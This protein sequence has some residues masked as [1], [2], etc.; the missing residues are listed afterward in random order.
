MLISE[1]SKFMGQPAELLPTDLHEPRCMP[2]GVSREP[3]LDRSVLHQVRVSRD[4][5]RSD[6]AGIR[7]CESSRL[8][9]P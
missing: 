2:G 1:E 8:N 4:I 5:P 6:P 9:L 3:E 7:S